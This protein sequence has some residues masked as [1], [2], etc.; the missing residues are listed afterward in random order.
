MSAQHAEVIAC[1]KGLEFASTL[2]MRRVI[3]ETDAVLVAKMLSDATYDRSVLGSLIG[4]IRSL[5]YNNF[6][7]CS[8]SYVSRVCNIVADTLA[9]MGL[10]CNDD[11]PRLWQD[12]MPDFVTLLVSSDLAG[13]SA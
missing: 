5:M 9:A 2:G 10:N 13:P 8:V 11:G 3:V 4:E 1:M 7:E 12:Q 6:Y